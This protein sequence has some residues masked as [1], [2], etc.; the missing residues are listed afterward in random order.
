MMDAALR[1]LDGEFEAFYAR[2]DCPS[3]TPKKLLR[4]QLLQVLYLVRS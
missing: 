3:I 1:D 2:R 4:A